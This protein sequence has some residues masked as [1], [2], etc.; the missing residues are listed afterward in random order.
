MNKGTLA[1]YNLHDIQ[2]PSFK[3]MSTQIHAITPC[4]YSLAHSLI[5]INQLIEFQFFS[6]M[7]GI[8]SSLGRLGILTHIGLSIESSFI[9]LMYGFH[10]WRIKKLLLQK[11]LPC[12][13][14]PYLY[15]IWKGRW[16]FLLH[17]YEKMAWNP[18]MSYRN[19]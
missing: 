15:L 9:G 17:G 13:I 10:K 18:N 6:H 5:S 4:T 19:P 14:F 8:Q 3:M 7:F 16:S 1:I 2:S 12:N 11:N